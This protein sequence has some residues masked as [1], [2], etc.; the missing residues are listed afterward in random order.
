MPKLIEDILAQSSGVTLNA[1][2]RSYI[3]FVL[4]IPESSA[5]DLYT[6]SEE[7]FTS[8]ASNTFFNKA[9]RTLIT[10]YGKLGDDVIELAGVKNYSSESQRLRIGLMMQNFVFPRDKQVPLEDVLTE[11]KE[12]ELGGVMIQS[13]PVRYGELS[14]HG[15]FGMHGDLDDE[16]DAFP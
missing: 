7:R 11:A 16:F 14:G 8:M 13:I 9:L 3:R 1:D 12:R 15:E 10:R 2:E 6:K 4:G 5:T